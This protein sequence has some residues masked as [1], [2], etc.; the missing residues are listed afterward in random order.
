MLTFNIQT[1]LVQTASPKGNYLGQ[2]PPGMKPALFAPG[3]ISTKYYEHSS[4][5][6]HGMKKRYSGLSFMNVEN[7][8]YFWK[9][10][11]RMGS[12]RSRHFLSLLI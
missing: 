7:P 11:R 10:D 9:C 8:H 2:K 4:P 3:I 12:D 1:S 5:A 6:F